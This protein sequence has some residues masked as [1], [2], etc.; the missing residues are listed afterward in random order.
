MVLFQNIGT[1]IQTTEFHPA[2][3]NTLASIINGK[4]IVFQRTESQTRMIVE[5]STKNPIHFFGGKWSQHHEGQFIGLS[6]N[7]IKSYDIR[8]PIHCAWKI[9][10]SDDL[11]IRDLD[12]NLKKLYRIV[13]GYDDGTIKIWDSRKTKESLFSRND[14]T[15]TIWSIRYNRS[16]D[17]LILS[18]G[19]DNKVVL[20]CAESVSS[21]SDASHF[22]EGGRLKELKEHLADGLL[23]TF[24]HHNCPVY[25]TE[26]SS[27][28]PWLFA[29]LS[30]DGKFV[31]SKVPKQ[32][33]YRILI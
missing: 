21:E 2:N 12:C 15:D 27:T 30:C 16:H 5:V 20:T 31:L 28:D 13:T 24:E 11:R 14:H 18:S 10:D 6:N 33:K 8:D 17:Q 22:L 25:S 7:R 26:W 23:Y 19:S 9:I 29:S 1:D 4:I 3:P 32:F